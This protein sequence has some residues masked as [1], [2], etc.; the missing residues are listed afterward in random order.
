MRNK[1]AAASELLGAARVVAAHARAHNAVFVVNDIPELVE[2]S[3]ADGVHVGQDDGSL[4]DVRARLP[5]GALVGRSTHSLA[6][7]RTAA[8][9]GAD[10]IGV[11]PIHATPTK[12]GRIPVGVGL[13]R[14]VAPVLQIPW[15]AIGGIDLTNLAEVLEAGATRVAVVRAVARAVDPR[16]AATALV[17]MVREPAGR[18]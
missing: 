15:F 11:G 2:A 13:V 8:S 17:A 12:P 9:E 10:Y 4:G 7:A 6:Q 5:R 16:L 1:S 18:T 14:E 3:G